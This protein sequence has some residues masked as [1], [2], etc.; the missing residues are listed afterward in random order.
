MYLSISF[1][2]LF[3]TKLLQARNYTFD[4][5]SGRNSIIMQENSRLYRQLFFLTELT[6]GKHLSFQLLFQS[7]C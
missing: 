7:Q 6:K 4:E 2:S 5:H 3:F 1:V